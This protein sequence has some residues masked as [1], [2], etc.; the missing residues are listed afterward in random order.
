[1][2]TNIVKEKLKYIEINIKHEEESLHLKRKLVQ[3][4]KGILKE[5]NTAVENNKEHI[6]TALLLLDN[7]INGR[8]LV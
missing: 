8:D 1:M 2:T 7:H 6:I 4:L 5:G 3:R